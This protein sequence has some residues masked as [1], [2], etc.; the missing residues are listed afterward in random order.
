MIVSNSDFTEATMSFCNVRGA[1][2]A[3]ALF[4]RSKLSRVDFGGS[5]LVGAVFADTSLAEVVGLDNAE[6]AGGSSV[7]IDTFFRS[8]GLSE[9][10]LRGTGVPEI[11]IKYARSLTGV[12]VDFN[13]CFISYSA[14]DQGFATQLHSS[15]LSR[16]I[17][18]WFA[19][20]SLRIGDRIRAVIDESIRLHDKLLLILST[21]SI[22]SAWVETEVETALELERQGN[23][24]LLFPVCI[25]DEVFQTSAPWAANVRRLRHIGD[26]RRWNDSERYNE[27]LAKL[28]RDLRRS[29]LVMKST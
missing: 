13:S 4:I 7:G 15:L 8:G 28:V 14:L 17:R 25:D 3:G 6:H 5:L 11:F 19:P 23:R 10:F 21:N 2:L 12:A 18:V 22:S 24:A 26:F 29:P 9:S 27:A 16:G 1:V 20:E